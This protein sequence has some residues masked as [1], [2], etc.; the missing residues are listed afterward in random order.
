M[1]T[2]KLEEM[3]RRHS[4]LTAKMIAG[5]VTDEERAE[6]KKLTDAIALATKEPE[7]EVGKTSL[8]VMT[9]AE[10]QAKADELMTGEPTAEEL[11]LL[12]RNLAAIKDQ[13]VTD[14]DGN[15]AVEV[16][17]ELTVEERN[18]ALEDRVAQLEAKLAEGDEA[19]AADADEEPAAEDEAPAEDET[20]KAEGGVAQQLAGEAVD[21][22]IE[23]FQGLKAKIEA[24]TLKV[25]DVREAWQGEWELRELIDGAAA[26]MG[27]LDA[28]KAL[29]EEVAP[30][31]EKLASDE[32][33]ADEAAEDEAVEDDAPAEDETEKGD[34]W[35]RGDLSGPVMSGDEAF[36][37]LRKNKG[38]TRDDS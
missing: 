18:K 22:L 24:G 14:A 33:P 28:A 30:Q 19:P 7:V 9:L 12:K 27:K 36:Q 31:L 2:K 4:A 16:L 26:V 21:A 29:I 10:F 23:R 25:D 3:V 37:H 5:D 13:G 1:I 38:R 32:A 15:V 8:A 17:V 6:L 11:A 35:S 20:G 34:A